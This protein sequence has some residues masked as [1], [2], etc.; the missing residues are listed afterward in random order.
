M[1]PATEVSLAMALAVP[2]TAVAF[3]SCDLPLLGPGQ[4]LD[5]TAARGKGKAVEE[6]GEDTHIVFTCYIHV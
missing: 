3:A 1:G 6:S 5:R 4:P 2:I